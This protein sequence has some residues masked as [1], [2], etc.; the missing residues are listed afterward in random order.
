ME[1]VYDTVVLKPSRETSR[2]SIAA[3][4]ARLIQGG[5][6]VAFPTETVYGLGANIFNES[7]LRALF[8]V[9]GRPG[10]N[11]LIVHVAR[12]EQAE[13]LAQ[14]LPPHFEELA[15]RFWPGPLTLVFRRNA[16]VFDSVT[17]GLP[18]VA[19]RAPDHPLGGAFLKAAGV[20]V[21]A[22]S[23]NLSGR[24][25]PTR[26]EH[27]LA[28]LGG[29]IP[30]LLDGGPCKIGIESTVLDLSG[31][32]PVILR[33]GAIGPEEIAAVTGTRTS[34]ARPNAVRPASPGMKYAHYAPETPLTL[35]LWRK[36]AS[37]RMEH[38]LMEVLRNRKRGLRVGLMAPADLKDLPCDAFFS[39]GAGTSVD[40]ARE[41]YRGLRTLDAARLDMMAAPGIKEEGLG[42]AVM[43]R[44]KK[45]AHKVI[46]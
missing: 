8:R 29:A 12:A 42:M 16:A 33:P 11:P 24:P 6:L 31:K 27:V 17:A 35:V 25:S 13:M 46:A 22:P 23:A 2:R 30:L 26:A 4:A 9:K 15:E 40:Y 41:M 7:A 28:D 34:I 39:L 1:K 43:N 5:E 44:L 19:V 45:A 36:E 18:T 10:D 20:P 3:E 14:R 38:L 21:A 32:H 37:V